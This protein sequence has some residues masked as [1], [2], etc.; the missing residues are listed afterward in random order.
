MPVNWRELGLDDYPDVVETPMDLHTISKHL[1]CGHYDDVDG[2]IDPELIFNDISLCWENCLHYF[3]NDAEVE[4]VQMALSMSSVAESLEREFWADLAAFE[5]SLEKSPF[6][7]KMAIAASI[8]GDTA[9]KVAKRSRRKTTVL[10]NDMVK[11]AADWWQGSRH[12]SPFWSSQ[13]RHR[14]HLIGRAWPSRFKRAIAVVRETVRRVPL[15]PSCLI[16]RFLAGGPWPPFARFLLRSF[17]AWWPVPHPRSLLSSEQAIQTF[18]KPLAESILRTASSLSMP[19]GHQGNSQCKSRVRETFQTLLLEA[20]TLFTTQLPT[21]VESGSFQTRW[22]RTPIQHR[23]LCGLMVA[24]SCCALQPHIASFLRR[25]WCTLACQPSVLIS[26]SLQVTHFQCLRTTSLMY[27]RA[28]S[29][30]ALLTPFSLGVI[31]LEA[32]SSCRLPR[33]LRKTQRAWRT[34]CRCRKV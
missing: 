10:A 3:E 18:L 33:N 5:E 15:S 6:K 19:S 31:V 25:L 29:N 27:T 9:K 21:S 23:S 12:E 32:T 17:A 26:G 2:L 28:S 14:D 34:L 16:S 8:M 22:S 13:D 7:T 11:Y 30:A 20:S 4:A 1:D 24:G